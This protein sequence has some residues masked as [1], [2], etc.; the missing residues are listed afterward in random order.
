MRRGGDHA[1]PAF[2]AT[3][4]G[5]IV[6]EAT[7]TEEEPE[8]KASEPKKRKLHFPTAITVLF[9][10]MLFA[11]ALTYIV[12]AGEYSKLLYDEDAGVLTI[13]NPDGSVET[14]EATQATLD[15]LGVSGK[16]ESYLD[17]SISKPVAVPGTYQR[18][19]QNPQGPLEFLLSPI[20]GVYDTIDIILF[21]FILGGCIGVLNYM[22]ALAAGV[23]AL[24]RLTRGKE[25]L[26]II[27]LSLLMVAGG[28][29]FGL[30]E[31]TIALYPIL[32]PVF[33]AAGY[34]AM[35]CIAVIFVGSSVG[36]MYSTVNPFAIGVATKAAGIAMSEQMSWRFIALGIGTAMALAYVLRY[37]HKV[38]LDPSQSV[39]YD[40]K[41]KIE[42][43]WGNQGEA[44]AFDLHMKL[45]LGAFGLAF[46]VLVYGIVRYL[47]W[48]DT[49]TSVFLACAIVLAF[50]S[51]LEEETFMDQFIGG[52]GDLMS[53]ALV[54]GV[55]RAVN[56]LLEDGLIS[57]T[58]LYF[59]SNL[60][61]GMSPVLFIVMMLVVYII[62]GFFINSSSGLAVLSIPIMAPLGDAVG[63]SKPAIIAAYNYGQGLISYITPT[64]LILAS[65]AMVDV[66]FSRW[67]K[68][69]NPLLGATIVL[70]ALL[71]IAQALIG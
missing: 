11:A 16:I 33:I 29:T 38:R 32:M 41:D 70:N 21:V 1:T 40:F 12:P 55:A 18:V 3:E 61:A 47:W 37:A 14:K 5:K 17:G 63:V 9:I 26:L 50:V 23:A 71:L 19:A 59:F 36:T 39:C 58:I 67:L 66:P 28:T 30:C 6:S 45:S 53:V 34:D 65:L 8:L 57:D 13:T 68:F 24:S 69:I 51:G 60:V 10:V 62:L 20:R 4:K 48:F 43:K 49:M 31:E 22:G 52:A 42:E 15:E 54:I 64:G 46:V 56:M 44:P 25:Y 27:I 35:T 7:M 2:N